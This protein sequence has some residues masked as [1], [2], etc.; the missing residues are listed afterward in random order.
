MKVKMIMVE[1]IIKII[2]IMSIT[3]IINKYDDM[4]L[5]HK[6]GYVTFV[7]CIFLKNA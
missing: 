2:I 1:V 4:G 5:Q 3:K 7:K 6:Y